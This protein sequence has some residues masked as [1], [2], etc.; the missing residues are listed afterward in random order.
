MLKPALLLPLLISATLGLAACA[1]TNGAAPIASAATPIDNWADRI[2]VQSEADEIRLASHATGLSGNQARALSDLHVRWMQAEGDVITIAAPR[3]S[4]QDA[5]AYR[6][7]ADAKTFL[8]SLGASPD[9]VRLI[10]YDAGGSSQAPVIVGYERYFA[11][12]PNCGGWTAATKTFN[13]EP[14]ANFGCAVSANI[15]AQVANPEDLRR[16][17]A[18]MPADPNR[19]SVVLDKYRKGDPTGSAR[20]DQSSGAISQAVQ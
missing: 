19:R 17:R 15:A 20:D 5:G 7:S 3:G 2:E 18:M 1:T 9:Q 4:G 14:N 12:T 13:D 8:L 6:V 10:G 16:G 11:V